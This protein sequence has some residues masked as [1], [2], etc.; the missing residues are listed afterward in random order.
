MLRYVQLGV[1]LL[2]LV[3]VLVFGPRLTGPRIMWGMEF[4][5]KTGVPGLTDPGLVLLVLVPAAGYLLTG[6]LGRALARRRDDD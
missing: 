3:L 4:K 6:L 2:G 1:A 5:T